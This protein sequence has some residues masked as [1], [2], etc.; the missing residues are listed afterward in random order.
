MNQSPIWGPR[1]LGKNH[2]NGSLITSCLQQAVILSRHRLYANK[3][4]GSYIYNYWG[5]GLGDG[6]KKMVPKDQHC[7]PYKLM[8]G[9]RRFLNHH[10]NISVRTAH[11]NPAITGSYCMGHNY[12]ISA[13]SQDKFGP[14]SRNGII[15]LD[16]G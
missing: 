14:V 6:S 5:W 7:S 16:G 13:I 10:R 15:W 3:S 2:G 4:I 11:K 9:G 8:Y 12:Y 1:H